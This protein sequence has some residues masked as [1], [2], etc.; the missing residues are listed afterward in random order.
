[1]IVFIVILIAASALSA[2]TPTGFPFTNEDLNYSVNW[3]TG[4]A[5]GEAHMRARQTGST[6]A[7]RW[8]FNLSLDASIPGFPI[9]DRYSSTATG[10]LCANQFDRISSHGPRKSN[11]RT[12]IDRRSGTATRTTAKGGKSDFPVSDCVKDALSFLYYARREMGQGKVPPS[13]TVLF[14]AAYQARLEYTGAQTV[15][16]NAVPTQTDRLVCNFT[17]PSSDLQFEIFFARDAAR[18]PVVIRAPFSI[19]TFSMEL[20]R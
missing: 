1:M 7:P 3:P 5:L 15:S 14:G 2:A 17:G 11:E 18:T 8:E 10:D 16:V 12:M 4:V 6:A 9:L 13:Q 20:L 19:G